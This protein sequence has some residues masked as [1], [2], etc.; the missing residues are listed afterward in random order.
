MITLLFYI[1]TLAGSTFAQD[2]KPLN[3]RVI[4]Y[5]AKDRPIMSGVLKLDNNLAKKIAQ[6]QEESCIEGMGELRGFCGPYQGLI[7]E[8]EDQASKCDLIKTGVSLVLDTNGTVMLFSGG[9]PNRLVLN[10]PFFSSRINYEPQNASV[11]LSSRTCKQI[12]GTKFPDD[13]CKRQRLSGAFNYFNRSRHFSG[14]YLVMDE[15]TGQS[16]R[17]RL[18]FDQ[19]E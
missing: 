7:T 17:Y 16:C 15:R 14:F 3:I 9:P 4:G 5:D 18:S 10:T 1:L 19:A 6:K 2:Q 8:E 13:N 12:I 11:E